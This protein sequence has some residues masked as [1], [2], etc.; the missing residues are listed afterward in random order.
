MFVLFGIDVFGKESVVVEFFMV[1]YGVFDCELF[2][3]WLGDDNVKF[4]CVVDYIVVY[5]CEFVMFDVICVV[6]DLLLLYLICVFNVCYGM[7]FYVFLID[8]CVQYGCIELCC[9][10]LIVEVVFDVGFVDQV[11]FQCV[12]WWIVVVMFGQYCSVMC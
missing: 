6:V 1:L 3:W 2:D 8:W 10:W 12:F 4:V 7:M 5:C 9:G 11:Y